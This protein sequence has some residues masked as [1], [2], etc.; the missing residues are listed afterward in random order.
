MGR[1][2]IAEKIYKQVKE[3]YEEEGGIWLVLYDCA[4]ADPE[5]G[6]SIAITLNKMMRE[7]DYTT[8]RAAE[9]CNLIR[10]ELG[11]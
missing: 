2:S 6:L 5:V 1:K 8:S 11:V 7:L 3:D 10:M 4:R 9:V